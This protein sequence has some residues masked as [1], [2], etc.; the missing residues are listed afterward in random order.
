M[1]SKKKYI[2]NIKGHKKTCKM[3]E[4]CTTI[5]KAK[6]LK[7]ENLKRNQISLKSLIIILLNLNMF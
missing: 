6:N 7:K 3:V 5:K 2:K 4:K 1:P